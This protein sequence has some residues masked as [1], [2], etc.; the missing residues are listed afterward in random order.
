[1]QWQVDHFQ[2]IV[3]GQHHTSSKPQ[4]LSSRQNGRQCSGSWTTSS[5]W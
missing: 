2:H 5:T 1:M 3:S 4:L